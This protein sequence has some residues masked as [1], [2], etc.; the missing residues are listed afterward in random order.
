MSFISS[1]RPNLDASVAPALVLKD[2][3]AGYGEGPV[4]RDF[5]LTVAAGEIGRAHV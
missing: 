4:L 5:N 1:G 3:E 2:V